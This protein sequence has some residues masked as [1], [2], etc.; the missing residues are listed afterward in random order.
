MRHPI[1]FV[2]VQPAILYYAWQIEVMLTNFESLKLHESFNIHCL[3]SYYPND[4]D[5][6][7]K[8]DYI[9]RVENR[10][11]GVA[12][13]F[14]YP[15]TRPHPVHYISSLRPNI[16]KRHLFGKSIPNIF[17]HDSDI[18]FTK[19]PDFLLKPEYLEKD[20]NWYVSDTISYIGYNYIKSKGDDVLNLMCDIV[21][22][23]PS[24]VQERENQAGGAQYLMKGVDY[25]FFD[26]MERD[27]E[28]MFKEVT[29]LNNE[30]KK[31]DPKH[32]EI[33]IWCSDMWSILWNG[34]LRG[35]N[36]N[37][38]PE[39]DFCWATDDMSKWDEKYIFH[40]AGAVDE[41]K[42]IIFYKGDYINQLP[43]EIEGDTYETKRASY[44]YFEIIKSIGKNSVLY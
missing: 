18:V 22:I 16:F 44:K 27:C 23:N 40:N 17:Y 39:M 2:C 13:F 43:Y 11:K 38:I 26:K 29:D 35:Y 14:F 6:K 37:I 36:T 4:K 8:I 30:K 28:R 19:F 3:F 12:E 20:N 33:Q 1:T 10:F 5:H 7:E 34:W 42:K 9:K 31:A 24:V 41:L 25:S 32:H 15:D 21:G